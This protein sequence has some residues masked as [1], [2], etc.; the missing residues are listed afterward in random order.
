MAKD[1]YNLF[2]KKFHEGGAVG[3][4]YVAPH[5]HQ[6]DGTHSSYQ[7]MYQ[8]APPLGVTTGSEFITGDIN[9]LAN[10]NMESDITYL[11]SEDAVNLRNTLGYSQIVIGNKMYKWEMGGGGVGYKWTA[12]GTIPQGKEIP[13]GYEDVNVHFGQETYLQS[14]AYTGEP[15]TETETETV[16]PGSSIGE[17]E[18]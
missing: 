7:L 4:E 15:G 10:W 5:D 8:N 18:G 17:R 12:Q 9:D 6:D 2:I 13:S 1:P 11:S 3:F 14:S 16:A